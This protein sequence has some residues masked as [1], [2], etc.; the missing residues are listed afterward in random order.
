MLVSAALLAAAELGHEPCIIMGD[1]KQDPLPAP[2]AALLAVPGWVDLGE[3]LGLTTS[4]GLGRLGTRIDRASA[5]SQA[6]AIVRRVSL[7]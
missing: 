7:R 3:S 2:A 1:F 5:T 4:P 6:A